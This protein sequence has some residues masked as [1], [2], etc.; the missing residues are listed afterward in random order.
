[1]AHFVK[2]AKIKAVYIAAYLLKLM[3]SI[4][5]RNMYSR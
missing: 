1:M 5:Q 4:L 3:V 2:I